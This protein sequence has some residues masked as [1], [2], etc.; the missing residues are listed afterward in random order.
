M[1]IRDRYES[2]VWEAASVGRARGVALT[3]EHINEVIHKFRHVHADNATSSLQRD[4]RICKKQTEL[5]TFSG[6]IVKEAKRLG[7]E[8]PLSEKMYQ[9]LKEIAEKF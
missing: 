4:Y 3:D 2:L 5:E 9:G 7:V 6:Y 1:C 8:I